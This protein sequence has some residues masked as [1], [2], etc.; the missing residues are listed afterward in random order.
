MTSCDFKETPLRH[1]SL[2]PLQ[3]RRHKRLPL[4]PPMAACSVEYR[5]EFQHPNSNILSKLSTVNLM[6]KIV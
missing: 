6:H 3:I 1:T 4:P 2:D 5:D